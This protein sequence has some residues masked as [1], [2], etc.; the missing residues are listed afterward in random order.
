MPNEI[1]QVLACSRPFFPQICKLSPLF[2]N[3]EIKNLVSSSNFL[4]ESIGAKFIHI[5]AIVWEL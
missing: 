2:K 5:S 4:M 1:R 3:S